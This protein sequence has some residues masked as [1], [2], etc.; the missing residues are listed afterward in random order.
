MHSLFRYLRALAILFVTASS[1]ALSAQSSVSFETHAILYPTD[2]GPVL[3]GDFNND[4][5]P[6]LVECC[7]SS[8]QLVFQAGNGDGTFKGPTVAY[9]TPVSV[10]SAVA[11]DVNGDGNLDIVAMAAQNPPPPPGSGFYYLTIWLGNGNGTFQPPE[12]YSVNEYAGDVAVGNFF[13]DG[14]PDVAVG[15]ST[16]TVYL[17]RNT[18]GGKFTQANSIVLNTSN[19]E[20][21]R[22]VAADFNGNG[23]SDLAASVMDSNNGAA[24]EVVTALWNDGSGNFTKQ[25]L[26]NYNDPGLAVGRLNG[27][28][29]IDLVVTYTCLSGGVPNY[30]CLGVDAYYGQGD[31]KL[32]QR[33]LLNSTAINAGNI[34]DVAAVDVN[35]DGYGDIA[36][37]GFVNQDCP[38]GCPTVPGGLLVW[39]GNADGSFQQTPQEFITANAGQLGGVAMA[40]FNRDGMMDFV[41]AAPGADQTSEVYINSTARPDCGTYTISPTVTVCQP[42]DNTYSPNPVRIQANTYDSSTVTTMQEYI[43]N[44]LKYSEPEKRFDTTF[45]VAPGTH[46]FVTKAWDTSGRSFV[47]D[48]TVTVYEGK[49]SPTCPAATNAASICLPS[50]TTS[51]S[52]VP[53]L[54]NGD[55]GTDIATAAQLYIDGTLI[56]DN[57]AQCAPDDSCYGADS[58]VQTSQALAAGS[59]NLVF[60]IWDTAGNVYEAQKTITVTGD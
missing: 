19:Y 6:D 1:A 30:Q 12:T 7:N 14:L 26:G 53:I 11:V 4:G 15:A 42:V 20:V 16:G 18:G 23:V 59:H 34:F 9:S 27:D 2:Q 8:T 21:V 46:F 31:N 49:P 10:A 39:L 58:Y 24:P 50:G 51:N 45:S 5:K 41:E 43:D 36:V 22:L 60:K 56:V 54:A 13:G 33:T 17:F 47:A 38:N 52:P 32:Y 28:A 29:N 25:L 55:T 48:R 37:F 35:G 3:S 40:D 57:K 44:A